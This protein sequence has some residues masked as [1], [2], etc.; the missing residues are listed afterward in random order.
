MCTRTRPSPRPRTLAAPPRPQCSAGRQSA[1]SGTPRRMRKKRSLDSRRGYPPASRPGPGSPS[2]RIARTTTSPLQTASGSC[3]GRR[4]GGPR[5]A[6]RYGG[7]GAGT[8][9]ASSPRRCWHACRSCGGRLR[10]GRRRMAHMRR[11]AVGVVRQARH[12]TE[13]APGETWLEGRQIL[14]RRC[15]RWAP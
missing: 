4:G 11:A 2:A 6:R 14:R 7:S 10:C 3:C 9:A 8:A 1:C 15:C 12:R 5:R 13:G